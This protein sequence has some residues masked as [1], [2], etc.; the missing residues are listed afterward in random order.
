MRSSRSARA[1]SEQGCQIAARTYQAWASANPLVAERAVSDDVE[2]NAAQEPA[3]TVDP[4][5]PMVGVR[6]PTAD[7]F[8]RRQK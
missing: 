1:L 7:G 3:C 2:M 5:G 6:R 8:Y 4:D